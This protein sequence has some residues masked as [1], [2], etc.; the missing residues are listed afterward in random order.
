[1]RALVDGFPKVWQHDAIANSNLFVK[2]WLTSKHNHKIYGENDCV[3]HDDGLSLS[4]MRAPAEVSYREKYL[5][6]KFYCDNKNLIDIVEKMLRLRVYNYSKINSYIYKDQSTL[7]RFI[8][9]EISYWDYVLKKY[10]IEIVVHEAMPHTH[11]SYIIYYLAKINNIKTMI[12]HRASD[13]ISMRFFLAESMDDLTPIR[14]IDSDDRNRSKP[15]RNAGPPV[16]SDYGKDNPWNQSVY[17]SD[18]LKGIAKIMKNPFVFAVTFPKK[19]SI[20]VERLKLAL[21][22]FIYKLEYRSLCTDTLPN[23]KII[24][25]PLHVRPEDSSYPVG[26][27]FEDI[28]Y[29]IEYIRGKIDDDVIIAIKEHPNQRYLDGNM[30][31]G[32]YRELMKHKNIILLDQKLTSD[33]IIDK[34]NI[35]MT[36][37]GQ[38]GWECLLKGKPVVLFATAW[39]TDFPY[40]FFVDDVDVMSLINGDVHVDREKVDEFYSTYLSSSY[41]GTTNLVVEHALDISMEDN[42]ASISGAIN[43]KVSEW[44]E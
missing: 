10:K 6:D 36:T 26:G 5:P 18:V 1:M 43:D 37:N 33:E 27:N 22:R 3:F 7:R 16:Y 31:F 15:K 13:G 21:V 24:Y 40:V 20:L 14:V 44:K 29:C 34:C 19:F 9:K 11:D 28:I 30:Y 25:F 23:K 2:Y 17:I 8:F 35:V 12:F 39:Y 4:G 42:I 32:Y 38:T 41:P